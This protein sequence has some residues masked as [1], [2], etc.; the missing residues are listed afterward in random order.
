MYR[1]IEVHHAD[2]LY[3]KIIWRNTPDQELQVYEITRVAYGQA[4]APF[5]ALRTLQQCATDYQQDYPIGADHVR[6]SFYVDD[7][8]TG[9]DSETDLQRIQHEVTVLLAKCH[10]PLAKWCSNAWQVNEALEVKIEDE[11]QKGVLGLRWIPHHDVLTYRIKPSPIQS[12]WTKRQVVSQIGQLF[13][14]NGFAAPA[15]ITAKILIQGLWKLT[16]DWDDQIPQHLC[17]QWQQY[18]DELGR[19][20]IRIPRWLGTNQNWHTEL[21]FFSDASEKAYAACAYAR[22]I[23]N[24]GNTNVQL[25]QSKTRVAPVKSA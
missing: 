18:L 19:M 23:D 14:P 15:I 5:L 8:L 12:N 13:D 16:L 22:T 6:T 2:R 17:H 25:I 20:D 7:L 10:L 9:A 21:H 24:N 3:Q 1:K 11:E 4:A